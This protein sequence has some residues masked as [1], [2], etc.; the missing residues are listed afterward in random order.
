M[1]KLLVLLVLFGVAQ[2]AAQQFGQVG[3]SG[4][5]LLKINFD[6]R[7][8]AIG[9]AGASVVDNA[10]ALYT[11]VAGTGYVEGGDVAFAYAPWFADL[12]LMSFAGAYHLRD[13][14]VVS[15]QVTGFSSDEEIT[16][17]EQENGTGER[18]SIS[19]LVVG[20]GFARNLMENLILGVQVKYYR[21]AYYNSSTQALAFDLGTNY[22]L[23]FSGAR[24]GIVL[25][26]FG[27]NIKPLSGTY[28]DY[29]D[30]FLEKEY[31]DSPL[32]VT[33]RA[34]F[35]IEPLVTESYQLRL[36]AD[37]VHPNDNIEHYNIGAE[38]KMFQFLAVRGGLKLNYDD[39]PFAAG[40]GLDLGRFAGTPLRLDYSYEH[41][42]ILKSIQ[43]ISLGVGF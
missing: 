12:K 8:S 14:G 33:F 24:I 9:Y 31:S 4:G 32:P 1:R 40:V 7:A 17:V 11:N 27:P 20:V 43:K 13:I 38:L 25:Q 5:Q 34:S 3:T 36:S 28:V 42:T 10:A 39:E 21:E 35:S 16:T 2:L 6:P 29:S 37:L 30:S 26:N 23:G 18:Y 41:F 15:L 19:N 22:S